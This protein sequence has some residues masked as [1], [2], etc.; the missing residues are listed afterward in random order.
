MAIQTLQATA[1]LTEGNHILVVEP[2]KQ[3]VRSIQHRATCDPLDRENPILGCGPLGCCGYLLLPRRTVWPI[4]AAS[5][6]R[7]DDLTCSSSMS[8]T[9]R[10][11]V[12]AAS[13]SSSVRLRSGNA[14][15]PNSHP[16]KTGALN[17][18][19][20]VL[21]TLPKR[22]TDISIKYAQPVIPQ[23][24]P[25]YC[26]SNLSCLQRL[27]TGVGQGASDTS[28]KLQMERSQC[29]HQAEP[30]EPRG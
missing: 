9:S 11:S 24:M 17:D 26:C 3:M 10:L 6:S 30:P 28:S 27:K 5:V 1:K 29:Q 19:Q 2:V 8:M 22:R 18:A 7:R 23:S 14:V 13:L 4:F 25:I 15:V 16:L 21:K 12:L 20:T